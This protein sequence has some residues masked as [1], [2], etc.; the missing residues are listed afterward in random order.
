MT[1]LGVHFFNATI[2]LMGCCKTFRNLYVATVIK[3]EEM[4]R[5][6]EHVV[7]AQK[8]PKI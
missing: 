8:E 7:V 3:I 5:D 6:L 2:Y 4:L 1:L